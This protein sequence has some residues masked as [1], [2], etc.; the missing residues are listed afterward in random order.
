M[1]NYDSVQNELAKGTP[2]EAL[3]ATCPW[4][5]NCLTPPT[6]TKGDIDRLTAESE[7]RD[8]QRAA[9]TGEAPG[10]PMGTILTTLMFTGKDVQAEVCP[11]FVNRL[12]SPEGRGIA[13]S[14][15]KTMQEWGDEA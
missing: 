5:R 4:D 3:C 13:D 14:L 12:R 1:S 2:A 6:M 11:V 15:R 7:E 8:K 10:L 9:E